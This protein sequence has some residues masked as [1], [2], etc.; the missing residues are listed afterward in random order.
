MIFQEVDVIKTQT[1]EGGAIEIITSRQGFGKKRQMFVS[2]GETLRGPHILL[3]VLI[4]NPFPWGV[5]S[6]K[7]HIW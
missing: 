3:S 6:R 2:K 1:T 5:C 7:S 4:T